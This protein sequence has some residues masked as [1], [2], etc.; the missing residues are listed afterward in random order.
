[1][2]KAKRSYKTA[3]IKCSFVGCDQQRLCVGDPAAALRWVTHL[4]R[5]RGTVRD[6]AARGLR[7]VYHYG[8]HFV[9]MHLCPTHRMSDPETVYDGVDVLH[10]L[11][12][13]ASQ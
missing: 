5:S 9:V 4:S 11:Q 10:E 1:M 2:T 6:S 7:C 3:T 13:G 8:F 12:H